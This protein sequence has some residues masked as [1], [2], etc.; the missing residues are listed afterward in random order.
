MTPTRIHSHR[1]PGWTVTTSTLHILF[2]KWP[3]AQ[4]RA[5]MID[6]IQFL[7]RS[8]CTPEPSSRV[9]AYIC[10]IS[11]LETS[12]SRR[13]RVTYIPAHS[14]LLQLRCVRME[15]S[16]SM[17]TNAPLRTLTKHA[18]GETQRAW[19]RHAALSGRAKYHILWQLVV[20][21]VDRQYI[22]SKPTCALARGYNSFSHQLAEQRSPGSSSVDLCLKHQLVLWLHR[23]LLLLLYCKSIQDDAITWS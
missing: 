10:G 11:A 3:I 19:L 1:V 4:H 7:T 8:N 22:Y 20:L 21:L 13:L 23:H 9:T 2:V 18:V 16:A 5:A 14:F 12:R 15:T 6:A 17:C